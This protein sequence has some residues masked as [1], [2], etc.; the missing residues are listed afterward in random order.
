MW[1]THTQLTAYS[2]QALSYHKAFTEDERNSELGH[3][4]QVIQLLKQEKKLQVIKCC[5]KYLILC[6][7]RRINQ[8]QRKSK[9]TWKVF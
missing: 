4:R 6:T 5:L 3:L 8:L 2:I 9:L 7:V 1:E